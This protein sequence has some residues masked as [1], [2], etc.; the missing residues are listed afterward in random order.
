MSYTYALGGM[1]AQCML[2]K[3]YGECSGN[4]ARCERYGRLQR[5]YSAL[6]D[7]E[8]MAVD[9][10]AKFRFKDMEELYKIDRSNKR[11][12]L[13][14]KIVVRGLIVWMLF[15]IA[16][17]SVKKWLPDITSSD[18]IMIMEESDKIWATI[19]ETHANLRDMNGDNKV[20]CTDYAIL[21]KVEWDKKYEPSDCEIVRNK[22]VDKDWHHLF[23]RCKK[24]G[25]WLCVEP[26]SKTRQY[27]MDIFWDSNSYKKDLNIYGET[28]YWLAKCHI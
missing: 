26:Q 17:C 19:T 27:A 28:E 3:K 22:N 5:C 14:K 2:D 15:G 13:F 10:A 24:D 12:E 21:F 9:D 8:K 1:K 11:W 20:N 18:K 4:C 25:E 7:F 16:K 6:N 23:V